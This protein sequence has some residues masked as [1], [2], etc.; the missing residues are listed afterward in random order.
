MNLD[1]K[2]RNN[3]KL[4]QLKRRVMSGVGVFGGLPHE[5]IISISKYLTIDNIRNFALALLQ[6]DTL[7]LLDDEY[8][9]RQLATRD[10]NYETTLAAKV[11]HQWTWKQIYRALTGIRR[12][13]ICEMEIHKGLRFPCHGAHLIIPPV[14]LRVHVIRPGNDSDDDEDEDEHHHHAMLETI[15]SMC[16]TTDSDRD[17]QFKPNDPTVVMATREFINLEMQEN[18]HGKT[19]M[20]RF[21]PDY[22]DDIRPPRQQLATFV[23]EG[24][25]LWTHH[26]K[27]KKCRYKLFY[28]MEKLKTIFEECKE[29]VEL[30]I[31]KRTSTIDRILTQKL[32]LKYRLDKPELVV[33]HAESLWR[34]LKR[35]FSKAELD[36]T[37]MEFLEGGQILAFTVTRKVTWL[38]DDLCLGEGCLET[39]PK[40]IM[41]QPY[42]AGNLM[43][44]RRRY[45]CHFHVM[46]VNV[47]LHELMSERQH[48][49][50]IERLN[51]LNRDFVDKEHHLN[52]RS[53]FSIAVT[54][55]T[56]LN[57]VRV[58]DPYGA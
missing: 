10:F 56:R 38:Y 50:T 16:V 34:R 20:K 48:Y 26:D 43:Q 8:L 57:F 46:M 4:G 29:E 58:G 7:S 9:F 21:F 55:D 54:K 15:Q 3:E 13:M 35:R 14:P 19:V 28:P 12:Q 42:D 23:Q 30:K 11:S 37:K 24:L 51:F 47:P 36:I 33:P 32:I 2:Y 22:P 27:I 39:I 41:E 52:L 31:L 6:R 25:C 17:L 45:L 5:A 49:L 18:L 1:L 40:H 44:A 53:K